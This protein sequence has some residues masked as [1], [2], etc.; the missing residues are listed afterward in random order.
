MDLQVKVDNQSRT[1]M[2]GFLYSMGDPANSRDQTPTDFSYIDFAFSNQRAHLE[3][4]LQK[5]DCANRDELAQKLN[6]LI[7]T[8]EQREARKS[9]FHRHFQVTKAPSE[10]LDEAGE[11]LSFIVLV[12][13][14]AGVTI[15]LASI[16][17]RAA[18][19]TLIFSTVAL[20]LNF[21]HAHDLLFPYEDIETE[22]EVEGE[23]GEK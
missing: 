9:M 12:A 5:R 4:E 19:T 13:I 10:Q 15:T 23:A 7:L 8:M 6:D 22:P 17:P 20:L 21:A 1:S 18:L 16:D 3:N 11:M 2:Q 14:I